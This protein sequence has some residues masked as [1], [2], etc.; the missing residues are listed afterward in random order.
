MAAFF[1]RKIRTLYQR[2]DVDGSGSIDV[3]DFNLW[4]ERLVAYGHLN[5]QQSNDL[6][7]NLTT[8]W[9][10]YFC[11]MDSNKDGK[12]TC[13]ELTKHVQ[14][15][16]NDESKKNNWKAI[17]P[18]IFEAIDADKDGAI[19]HE[20]FNNY[21]RS[22]NINDRAMAEEVFHAIDTNDDGSLSSEEFSAFGEHFFTE[23][24]EADL[25]KIFFGR[26]VD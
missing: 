13:V 2:F 4:G 6:R 11:P 5:E 12:V 9:T 25:S 23:T 20:E 10:H 14:A 18:L 3:A 19:S 24:N 26:L 1:E 7:K 15:S 22:L 17:I 21:F 16:L 8:L